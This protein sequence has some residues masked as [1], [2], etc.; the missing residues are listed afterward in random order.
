MKGDRMPWS[1]E[2]VAELLAVSPERVLGCL[3]GEKSR[4]LFFPGARE[5]SGKWMIPAR[6]VRG[7]RPGR[8]VERLYGI[9]EFAELIGFSYHHVFKMV[10]AGR[11]QADLVLGEKRIAESE[12]W[13]LR[14]SP[15]VA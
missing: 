4:L 2:E 10:S 6:D 3:V 9:R 11:I 5:A 12:Y 14:R 13:R 7:L 8:K 15:R 1:V